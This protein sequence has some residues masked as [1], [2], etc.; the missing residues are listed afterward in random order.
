MRGA[1]SI[2]IVDDDAPVLKSLSRLLR[3]RGFRVMAY[4]SAEDFLAA[5]STE[6]PD[7]LIVDQR[8]PGMTGLELLLRL[9][10]EGTRVPAIV[11]TAYGDALT[12]ERCSEAGAIAWLVKPLQLPTLLQAIAIAYNP[13]GGC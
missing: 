4:T 1:C 2:A 6:L 10:Q 11:I 9:E 13:E 8:M 12:S 7:C 3:G 5:R